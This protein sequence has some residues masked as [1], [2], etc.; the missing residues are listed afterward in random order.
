M[1]LRCSSPLSPSWWPLELEPNP[2]LHPSRKLLFHIYGRQRPVLYVG[3]G[4]KEKEKAPGYWQS[5]LIGRNLTWTDR[6]LWSQRPRQVFI[7]LKELRPPPPSCPP[8]YSPSPSL[9]LHMLL[10]HGSP[11]R[12]EKRKKIKT[13]S[14]EDREL[15]SSNRSSKQRELQAVHSFL[16]LTCVGCCCSCSCIER[17]A[18]NSSFI[19]KI[20]FFLCVCVCVPERVTKMMNTSLDVFTSMPQRRDNSFFWFWLSRRSSLPFTCCCCCCIVG[21]P[22]DRPAPSAFTVNLFFRWV[23]AAMAA[24]LEEAAA[25]K[26]NIYRR[27]LISC[28]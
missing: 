6:L 2:W 19:G 27:Q 28:N 18:A 4:K 3:K 7:V 24:D 25:A 12:S 10:F 21:R 15:E 22:A 9:L 23:A 26:R 13:K 20:Y 17:H 16:F 11:T 8:S 14:K 1:G 5:S